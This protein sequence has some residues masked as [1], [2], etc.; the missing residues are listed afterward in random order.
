M[1]IIRHSDQDPV[2][3][4]RFLDRRY[5][6][7]DDLRET[8]AA[9]LNEVQQR[10]DEALLDLTERFDKAD[11]RASGIDVTEKEFA[12]AAAQVDETLKSA[13]AATLENV[14][15]FTRRS[16]RANWEGVNV[17]GAAIG[18]VF[19]PLGRVG[20]YVPGGSAPLVST[21]LMTVPIAVEAGVPEIVVATPCGP[22]GSVNP[23]LLYALSQA[24]AT[25]VYKLGGAQAIA[26]MAFGTA[27]IRPV[28]KVYGPGNRFVVEA[29]RQVFGMVGV[30]LLPGPSEVLVLADDS[31][32]ADWI[33]ADML[34]QAEHGK[35]S[36]VGLIT[37]SERLLGEVVA[38]LEAQAETLTRQ[39]QLRHVLEHG[40]FAVLERSLGDAVRLVNQFAPEHLS[41]VVRDADA[42]LP[43]IRTAGAIYVGPWSAVA[44]GDFLAGPSHELPTGGAG[45]SFPGLT[46][47]M[48]QRR[49]SIV[50]F[51]EAATRASIPIVETLA[52]VEGLDAHGRSL[53]LRGL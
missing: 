44:A 21:A 41:L 18:E 13:V 5:V 32:R 31:A 2:A 3:A 29:K 12:A 40:T 25:E 30:D 28:E 49:T 6:P 11:L 43:D 35:D 51:D 42:L 34:A 7:A 53:T 24:G 37:D 47:E 19:H 52:R 1:K 48:F 22:D 9:I 46:A 36:Q 33:A 39:D 20:I 16:L 4:L 23:A 50:R 45:K 10:G 27:S 14:R 8:V 17:Q 15:H 26:A 38:Q